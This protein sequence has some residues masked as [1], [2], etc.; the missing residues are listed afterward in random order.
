MAGDYAMKRF[1]KVIIPVPVLRCWG[2]SLIE[3]IVVVAILGILAAVALPAYN[4]SVSKARRTDAGS[5]LLEMSQF[6]ERYYT[7]QNTY[8]SA[9]L[10]VTES[11][12]DGAT[13]YYD[14]SLGSAS[15]TSYSVEAV[16]KNAM[17]GDDCATLSLSN[18]GVKLP[19]KTP[20]LTCWKQ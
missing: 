11:P 2:F 14:I 18:A 19:P 12:K 15:A 3:I 9:V 6:M 7:E 10:P 13:K 16:P 1:K 17:L 4:D 5:V 8:V 20:I